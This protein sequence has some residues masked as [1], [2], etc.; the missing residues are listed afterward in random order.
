MTREAKNSI[1]VVYVLHTSRTNIG[2]TR[3]ILENTYIRGFIRIFV[4]LTVYVTYIRVKFAIYTYMY[5]Y[6]KN[7]T[8][9]LFYICLYKYVLFNTCYEACPYNMHVV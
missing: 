4:F 3:E 9:L 6:K 2:N 8:F 1:I 7:N 5:T